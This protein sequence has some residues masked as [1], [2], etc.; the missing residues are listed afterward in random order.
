MAVVG[1]RGRSLSQ[2]CTWQVSWPMLPGLVA[3][4]E[5]CQPTK[6]WLNS[7]TCSHHCSPCVQLSCGQGPSSAE[8]AGHCIGRRLCMCARGG[9]RPSTA[10]TDCTASD[11]C[12]T[13]AVGA[14]HLAD[15]AAHGGAD[16]W[17]PHHQP[18][19]AQPLRSSA[20]ATGQLCLISALTATQLCPTPSKAPFSS[21]KK[22]LPGSL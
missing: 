22:P 5:P 18:G 9:Q 15:G 21:P 11:A 3:R 12:C 8:A 20:A 7:L 10:E 4:R 16:A 6:P 2:L 19:T 14:G 1:L 13:C 17:P